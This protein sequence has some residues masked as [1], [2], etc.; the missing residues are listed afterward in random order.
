M[1]SVTNYLKFENSYISQ[2]SKI[3]K[4]FICISVR[5]QTDRHTHYDE[6]QAVKINHTIHRL[7]KP[8]RYKN[9]CNIT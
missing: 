9:F 1:K 8:W 3:Y 2:K 7:N 4:L 5:H 6:D